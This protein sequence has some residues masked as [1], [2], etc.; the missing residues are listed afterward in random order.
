MFLKICF[1][2]L[3]LPACRRAGLPAQAGGVSFKVI[4]VLKSLP[5][6]SFRKVFK[7]SGESPVINTS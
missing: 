1:I 7:N 6:L 2:L 5:Y 3:Y 4:T